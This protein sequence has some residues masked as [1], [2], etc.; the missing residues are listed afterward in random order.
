[1]DI[2]IPVKRYISN[3]NKKGPDCS[4]PTKSQKIL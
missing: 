4:G 1:M 2:P 3:V